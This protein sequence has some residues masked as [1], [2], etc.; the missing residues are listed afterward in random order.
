MSHER[1]VAQQAATA[2]SLGK[3]TLGV[4]ALFFMIIAASAPL[5]V[6]AG[7]T[8]SNFAVTGVLGIPLSFILLGVCLALF[9]V[10]Y[11]AMSAHIRNAGA[12]YAYI[13]Q[14][15]GRA[16]GVGAAWVALVAYNAMQVGIYGLFG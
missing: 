2:S 16:A 4:P 1:T 8:T 3:R 5:T 13:S 15:L 11:A 7:G 12:F 9:A 6:V 14:G 10:G